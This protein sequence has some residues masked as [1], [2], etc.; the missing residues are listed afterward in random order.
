MKKYL[1]LLLSIAII[2][3][4]AA[5]GA[6]TASDND[7]KSM[8][9]GPYSPNQS[10]TAYAYVH[11]GY[12]GK[13]EVK[14]DNTGKLTVFLDDAFLPHVLAAVDLEATDWNADNTMGY[15]SHGHEAF[16]AKYVS[17]NDK[18]YVAVKTGTS[19]SYVEADDKGT[20]VGSAD[21]EKTIL[22]HQTSMAAY[23][24]LISAGKFGVLTSF[25]AAVTP[26][27][28]TSYGG[29]TKKTAPGYWNTGQT[30]IGNITEIENFIAENGLQFSLSKM[31]KAKD[32]NADGLKLWSVADAVTGATNSDFKDYFGLAQ[33]AAGRLKLQ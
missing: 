8:V 25:G 10:E 27:T 32:D 13:A 24:A 15:M 28:T 9:T 33:A 3:G 19:F 4:L 2:A 6:K 1:L 22:A 26:V 29:I 11:A 20:A 16:V 7:A 31:A 23:Y 21:L 17:Y 14:V 30:W 18:V 5:C 12:V